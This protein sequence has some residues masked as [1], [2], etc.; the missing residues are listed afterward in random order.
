MK[1]YYI[2]ESKCPDSQFADPSQ[3]EQI[4]VA[5]SSL[6]DALK[7]I[8]RNCL[9]GDIHPYL[10]AGTRPITTEDINYQDFADYEPVM[11]YIDDPEFPH[12]SKKIL[13]NPPAQC[14]IIA[15]S[16]PHVV[17]RR[18]TNCPLVA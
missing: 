13:R 16:Q 3:R 10:F 6:E 1:E 2:W 11:D 5:A 14:P 18:V 17:I 12:Q 8:Q 7:H 9:I 4:I 15:Y